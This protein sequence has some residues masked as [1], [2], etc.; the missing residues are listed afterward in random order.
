M[1]SRFYKKE[2]VK[3][4][5]YPQNINW[6]EVINKL[7]ITKSR[8]IKIKE[9]MN[10]I[11]SN[12][13]NVNKDEIFYYSCASKALE[14]ALN[15]L[16]KEY[17]I[18]RVYIPDYSCM[19]LADTI[20]RCNF[21]IKVYD[22]EGDLKPSIET[23]SHIGLDKNAVLILPSLF[24]KNKYSEEFLEILSNLNIPIILDEAQAFPNISANLYKKLKRY[25]VIISFGKSKP[26]SAIGGGAFINNNLIP[27]NMI[28]EL[29]KNIQ[30]D[31]YVKEILQETKK[32]I[33]NLL[34]KYHMMKNKNENIYYSLEDLIMD[35]NK[36]EDKIENITKLQLI[37]AYCK[38]NKYKK[39]YQKRKIVYKINFDLFGEKELK[40]YNYLPIKIENEKR[41][42]IMKLLGNNQ[43]QTTIYYYPLHL[44]PF[45]N[46]K[47]ILKE[48]KNS[49]YIFESIL[50]VPFGVDYTNHQINKIIKILNRCD[51]K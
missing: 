42:N 3:Y 29:E 46:H 16:K 22:I 35:K 31:N 5:L 39:V 26:I 51:L 19:E 23:I 50:I 49:K 37:M 1:D 25:V 15:L 8:Y 9:N 27:G 11:I 17:P 34:K 20:C 18:K 14:I 12:I 2:D 47:F 6:F 44:I 33:L 30:E 43:I 4:I 10:E 40:D 13:F 45:Y 48:C 38:L 7:F 32:R 28:K 36:Y 21:E 41:Y 24:G